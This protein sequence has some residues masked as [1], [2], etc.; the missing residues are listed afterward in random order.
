M[1]SRRAFTLV[2]LVVVIAIIGLLLA[3]LIPAVQVAREAVRRA[4]CQNNLKEISLA[5]PPHM[6]VCG[7]TEGSNFARCQLKRKPRTPLP[8]EG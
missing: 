5:M 4:Q 1:H 8:H 2:E 7:I 3:L 6:L